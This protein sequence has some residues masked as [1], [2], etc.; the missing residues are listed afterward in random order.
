MKKSKLILS[1]SGA[2][3]IFAGSLNVFA[4]PELEICGSLDY[5]CKGSMNEFCYKNGITPDENKDIQKED[6]KNFNLAFKKDGLKK[7]FKTEEEVMKFLSD[8]NKTNEVQAFGLFLKA[9]TAIYT[10][11]KQG[12]KISKAVEDEILNWFA[13]PCT[14]PNLRLNKIVARGTQF[15]SLRREAYKVLK[16]I[17]KLKNIE[18]KKDVFEATKKDL[19]RR[20]NE[21]IKSQEKIIEAVTGNNKNG[22]KNFIDL[23][24]KEM[25]KIKKLDFEKVK[26]EVT[27]LEWKEDLRKKHTDDKSVG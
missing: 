3:F 18:F 4:K 23:I 8:G 25:K 13:K 11:R 24:T 16:M 17:L 22:H 27:K 10:L 21:S 19:L 26:E 9:Y 20:M 6:I 5:F 15:F 14:D 1:L 12:V 7:V 2:L